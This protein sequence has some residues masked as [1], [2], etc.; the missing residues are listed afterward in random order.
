MDTMHAIQAARAPFVALLPLDAAAEERV[1][2]VMAE[3]KA[4]VDAKKRSGG[5]AE[6]VACPCLLSA[7][8]ALRVR[9]DGVV[10]LE[11]GRAG[12][13]DAGC[14]AR[15]AAGAAEAAGA[16]ERAGGFATPLCACHAQHPTC[17]PISSCLGCEGTKL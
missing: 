15:A 10:R 12:G 9:L 17:S 5:T 14:N 11:A 2:A 13:G 1:G 7:I 3:T 4:S 16:D 6:G 8:P